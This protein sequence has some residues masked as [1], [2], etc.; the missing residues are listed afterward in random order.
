VPSILLGPFDDFLVQ[1]GRELR[2]KNKEEDLDLSV[3]RRMR[4]TAAD[5]YLT[6]R[7]RVPPHCPADIAA[8]YA[9]QALD[10]WALAL[11]DP[12][13][14]N[15]QI[16]WVCISH[17]VMLERICREETRGSAQC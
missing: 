11:E 10:C 17:W 12:S 5:A 4:R 7:T 8:A 3:L 13:S 2:A 14:L 9:W 16:K 6:G 15:H 1:L